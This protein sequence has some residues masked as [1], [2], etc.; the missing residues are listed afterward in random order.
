MSLQAVH[1]GFCKHSIEFC[2]SQS[3]RVLSRPG[4]R[5]QGRVQISVL[6]RRGTQLG[7]EGIVQAALN[8]FDLHSGRADWARL[9]LMGK[10]ERQTDGSPKI[11][12]VQLAII[13][14]FWLRYNCR[15]DW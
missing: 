6:G 13:Y 15:Q 5:V 1:K 9:G 7:R 10:G 12:K 14:V 8:H 2:S 4:K 11:F 3:S